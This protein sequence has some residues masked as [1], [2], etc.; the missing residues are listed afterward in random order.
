[1]EDMEINFTVKKLKRF[2]KWGFLFNMSKGVLGHCEYIT[3]KAKYFCDRCYTKAS[4]YKGQPVY[5]SKLQTNR[6]KNI[7]FQ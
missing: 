5:V 3:V 4:N 2:L 7:K 1:M 6:R